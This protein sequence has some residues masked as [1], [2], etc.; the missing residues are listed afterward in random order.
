[1][2]QAKV[3]VVIPTYHELTDLE[4]ISLAQCRKVL[5][6]YPIVFVAPEGKIFSYFQPGDMIAHFPPQH[7]QSV[8]T[9]SQ[10]MLSPDFYEAFRDFEYILLYQLDAFVF[11]DALEIFCAFGY[12]FIGAPWP[13]YAWSGRRT[14]KTP[15]VGNG[16]FSLRKVRTCQKLLEDFSKRPDWQEFLEYYEDAIFAFCGLNGINNFKTA[17]V[18]LAKRFSMEWWPRRAIKLLDNTLPFGCHNWHSFSADFYV[19]LFAQLGYDLQPY[20]GQMGNEDYTRY[21]PNS[22]ENVATDR[23]V[24]RAKLR[25]PITKYLPTKRFASVHVI[26]SPQVMKVL[27]RLLDED[28]HLADKV[29][30]YTKEEWLTLVNNLNRET[31]PHLILTLYGDDDLTEILEQRAFVYGKHFVSFRREYMNHCTKLFHGLGR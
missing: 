1:M 18:E 17:P 14:P 2:P 10:F 28:D 26:R 3:A 23:L 20:R 8:K 5:G 16:G 21:L 11:Y 12:D 7:F 9:Y 13:Y 19:E 30:I 31:L 15:R 29:F 22:L 6:N 24:R 27:G 4:K 25:Q